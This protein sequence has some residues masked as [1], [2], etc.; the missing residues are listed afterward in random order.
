MDGLQIPFPLNMRHPLF[1]SHLDLAHNYWDQVL[2]AEDWAVDATCGNGHDTLYLAKKVKKGKLF[3]I[4]KQEEALKAT[5]KLVSEELPLSVEQT[6]EYIKGC[7]SDFPKEIAPAT[8]QL[9]VYNLGYL[10]GGDKT[11]TTE[12]AT[13]LTSIEKALELIKPGGIIT[14]TCYPGHPEGRREEGEILKMCRSID[15][16]QWSCTHMRWINRNELSPS[17]LLL[18]KSK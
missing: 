10:P 14:I 15:R 5:R 12:T 11:I 8:L 13:T 1:D 2:S 7:H 18:Q 4:D 9:I 16:K 17:L 6:I 3:V